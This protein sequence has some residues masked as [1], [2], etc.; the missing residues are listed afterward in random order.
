MLDP[1]FK[2]LPLR[3]G[4]GYVKALVGRVCPVDQTEVDGGLEL[5]EHQ[6]FSFSLG[7]GDKS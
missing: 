5:I 3:L 6:S 1:G 7:S 2:A 4:A